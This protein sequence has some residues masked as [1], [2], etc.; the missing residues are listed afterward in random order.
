MPSTQDETV[1]LSKLDYD[2][3]LA[4]EGENAI[5]DFKSGTHDV[6][7]D[8]D[9]Q[10]FL[11]QSMYDAFAQDSDSGVF[12]RIKRDGEESDRSVGLQGWE[13]WCLD[14]NQQGTQLLELVKAYKKLERMQL[15]L[16]ETK[17]CVIS[18]NDLRDF[19]QQV[20]DEQ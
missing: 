7:P 4:L 13:A 11:P 10:D 19:F 6:F 14:S 5:A 20:V 16:M 12:C 17:G 18:A 9:E 3:A 2:E 8:I 15:F 1:T